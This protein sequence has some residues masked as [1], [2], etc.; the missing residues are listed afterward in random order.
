ML[1]I[2]PAF[3]IVALSVLLTVLFWGPLWCG[4]GFVGGDLYPYFFPQKTFLAD[5]LHAGEFPL[6]NNLTG[7]GYPVLGE[8]Q[9]GAAYPPYLLA[10]Y[11]LDVNTAYNV[12]HLLHYV[13]CFAGTWM[14]GRRIGLGVG[15][16]VLTA[17]VFTYGWFPTRACLEWAI[18]TGA[19]LPVALWCVESF[20]QTR[21]WRY[22]IGLS[23]VLGLQLLAGHFHLAFITQLLVVCYGLWRVRSLNGQSQFRETAVAPASEFGMRLFVP[24]VLSVAAGFLL[25][26][27]Q[28]VP[29]WE[30]KTRSS[31][32]A[33][34]DGHE[35]S[36]GHLPPL[37][38]SQMF[39]PWMWYSPWE[40][41]GD[42]TIRTAAELSAP[43]HWF[44]PRRNLDELLMQSRT[45][46][47]T[48]VATNRVEAHLY[49]GLV[50]LALAGWWLC[51][52]HRR[53]G[54]QSRSTDRRAPET[55]LPSQLPVS[56]TDAEGS[57]PLRGELWFWVI[58]GTVAVVYATGWLLPVARL[59]PGFNFF[60]GPGRYGI[61][62]TLAVAI[63][64]G[65]GLE[66][67]LEHRAAVGR[68]AILGCVLWSTLGDLWLVS[69]M[70]TY[71]VMVARPPIAFRDESPIRKLLLA[72]TK[73][74]RLYV[75]AQNIGNLLGVSCLPVYLGIQPVEY[76]DP[77][78]AGLGMPQSGG[79][80]RPI[81]ADSDF[82]NWLRD[83]GVTHI[84]SF[85]PLDETSW[86]ADRIWQG[87]DPMLNFAL[88]RQ[89][90][91]VYLYKFRDAPGRASILVDGVRMETG[92]ATASPQR[93]A[94]R[95][96]VESNSSQPATV[97][98]RELQYPGWQVE[99]DGR[100]ATPASRGMFREVDVPAGNH[101]VTWHYRPFSVKIG[102][103]VTV[104]TALLL[105]AIGHV[106]FWHRDRLDRF[107]ARVMRRREHDSHGP[108]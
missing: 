81:P 85:D 31:R 1:L 101:H 44:G 25:A 92:E 66:S 86:R 78:F 49:C 12:Q 16:A 45:G 46:G 23:F 20:V 24:L 21:R 38:V 59:I 7:F 18:V 58:A 48:T 91:P 2:R 39:A 29:T 71:A 55:R 69:R 37:Y 40:I 17:I 41:E 68:V 8:S 53:K 57:Y 3:L 90:E 43:W 27:V 100:P 102:L 82:S 64:A 74:A 34:G 11:W 107:F 73:A 84:L 19:W 79:S 63:L 99:V 70:V 10:Y 103:A 47:L 42:G 76:S 80:D 50:P 62:T 60:R 5:R 97:V 67:L 94:N 104:L 108:S 9:T 26:A 28:L 61:V 4:Y 22:A 87:I 98:A 65:R 105:A 36:Y 95:F 106:R 51:V 35:P 15:G 14:F 56:G 77:K 13:I 72:E 75:P 83:S 30:L 52:G 54:T 33:V 96:V 32:A 6:W 89:T 88:A 93:T